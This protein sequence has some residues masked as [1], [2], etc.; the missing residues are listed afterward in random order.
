MTTQII[1]T[2]NDYQECYFGNSESPKWPVQD[3]SGHWHNEQ[4]SEQM[5]VFN[6]AQIHFGFLANEVAAENLPRDEENELILD[7]I[8]FC[9]DKYYVAAQ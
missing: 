3:Q 6:R 2:G 7:G 1:F 9:N 4:F 8:Y 5:V